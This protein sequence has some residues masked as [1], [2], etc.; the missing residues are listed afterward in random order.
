MRI[1]HNSI[2]N[3]AT[4]I[5]FL[6]VPTATAAWQVE[7]D[8]PING[9]GYCRMISPVGKSETGD[10]IMMVQM[11]L[12]V[13]GLVF[14]FENFPD[15]S[16]KATAQF[17]VDDEPRLNARSRWNSDTFV[18]PFR[19]LNFVNE[20]PIFELMITTGSTFHLDYDG[21]K[22]RDVAISLEGAREA[23]ALWTQCVNRRE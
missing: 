18:V 5:G 17:W 1:W 23:H 21:D 11:A 10:V 9:G 15:P 22:K 20:W 3:M 8:W 7:E 19:A 14:F 16:A 13:Q 12:D 6:I 2:L 4:A